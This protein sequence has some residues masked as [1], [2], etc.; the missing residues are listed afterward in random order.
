[1]AYVFGTSACTMATTSEPAFVPGVWGPYFS[2]MV[3]GLW[4]NEGGQSAA[5]AAIDHLVRFHP[6]S[7][8]ASA[9]AKAQGLGLAAWLGRQAATRCARPVRGRASGR[10]AARRAGIPRQPLALR[11]SRCASALIAGLGMDNGA[12]QPVALYRRRPAGHRLWRA[13]DRGGAWP[14]K[15]IAIDTIV[16]S[17]GAAQSDLVRQLLADTTGLTVAGST[18]PEPVL[19]GSAILAAVAAGTLPRRDRGDDRHVAH[20]RN[21]SP[22]RRRSDALARQTFAAFELLQQAGRAIRG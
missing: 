21:L 11:R 9:Q 15:G 2:A 19:L 22:G 5:G 14:N 16:V 13:P 20:R 7:A 10:R 3:P 8:D 18:S 4:L 1:M 6:A 12:R 17:G